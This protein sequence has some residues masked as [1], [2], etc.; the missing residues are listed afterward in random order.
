MTVIGYS[1]GGV[2]AW[3]WDVDYGGVRKAQQ[4]ITLFPVAW[5]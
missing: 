2:V 5:R 1:A 3:L 4:I